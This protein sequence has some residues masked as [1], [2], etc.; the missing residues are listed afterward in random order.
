MKKINDS[1]ESAVSPVV[2]VLLMLVVT[3]I[4]AAVVSGFAGGLVSGE[5]KAPQMTAET[6]IVNTGYYYGSFFTM[7]ITGVSEVIPS[8][9]TKIITSWRNASGVK[10]GTTV[11]PNIENYNYN[12][13]SSYGK[14]PTATGNGIKEWGMMGNKLDGQQYGNYS[15]SSSTILHCT[16]AGAFGPGTPATY[17]GYGPGPDPTYVYKDGTGYT[18]A[19]ETDQIQAVLGKNWNSLRQGDVVNVKMIHTPSGK[20]IYEQNVVVKGA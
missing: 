2:G 16:A 14:A 20:T 12:S 8:K 10:N 9:D 15:L 18:Y 6:E 11:L 1:V 19:T 7:T 5:K 4:I 13:G 17:G 3:I